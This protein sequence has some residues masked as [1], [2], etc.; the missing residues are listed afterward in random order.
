MTSSVAITLP[1]MLAAEANGTRHLEVEVTDDCDLS[2]LL[3]TMAAEYPVLARRLRDET[4]SLRKFVNIY[5]DGEDVRQ[6][7]GLATPVQA[8]QQIQIIQSVAGG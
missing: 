5:L 1:R 8:G 4:G 2:G 3:S 7:A 6:L